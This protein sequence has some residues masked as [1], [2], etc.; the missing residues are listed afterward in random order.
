M[1]EIA[2]YVFIVFLLCIALFA[3]AQEE[4]IKIYGDEE[5]YVVD[6]LTETYDNGY[7]LSGYSYTISGQQVSYS[8]VIKTDINGE[9]LWEK[10]IGA[11]PD[12]GKTG[13]GYIE[14]TEDGGYI[15]IG[16]TYLY[17]NY[18]DA[19]IL[20]LNACGEKEWSKI[21]YHSGSYEFGVDVK[22]MDN[23]NYL[24][25]VRYWGDDLAN[26]R[27]WLFKISQDSEIIWQKVY[28]NWTSGTNAEEG[29]HLLKDNNNEYLI[30]GAYYQYNPGEDTNARYVRPMF[31]KIDSL[32]NE[33]W[34]LLWG[35]N[36]FY[37]G[38]AFESLNNSFGSIY[39][40]GVNES[41]G[42]FEPAL[43]KLDNTGNQLYHIDLLENVLGGAT[44]ISIFED[45]ALFIGATWTDTNNIDSHITVYKIDTLGN[46]LAERELL[47]E[48]NTIQTSMITRDNKYLVSGSFYI[49]D[50]NWD[51][52]LWKFNLNLEYDSIY[53]Q[54][55]VYDS[56]CPY[57]IVSDTIDLDTT[58]VNL[59]ELYKQMHRMKVRP[60]PASSKLY[61]TLGDLASGTEIRLYNTSGT[62]ENTLILLSGQ[63]EYEMDISQLPP[64]LYVAILIDKGRINDK[65]KVV[66]SR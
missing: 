38:T 43:Y 18:G 12:P 53:T 55:L 6:D 13:G 65:K 21:F 39:S 56:L 60:N 30:T 41:P 29:Y 9:V 20:R 47:L 59:P 33:L 17:D 11:N 57:P 48:S 66:I 31:I 49:E 61:F 24:M 63:K 45:T 54:P 1:K 16:T 4:W 15:I 62:M 26:E 36:D 23:G 25:M 3:D 51:I 46:T 28:A 7:I 58:T 44:S 42:H 32:G 10:K 27:I 35:L 14:Q 37:Y 8:L 40:I 5:H 52:Y 34:H 22:E 2:K 64:G 19:F 50:E